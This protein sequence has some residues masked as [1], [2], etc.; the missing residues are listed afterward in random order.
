MRAALRQAFNTLNDAFTRALFCRK[1]KMQVAAAVASAAAGVESGFNSEA[2]PRPPAAMI[3]DLEVQTTPHSPPFPRHPGRKQGRRRQRRQVPAP[4][5]GAAADGGQLGDALASL[6]VARQPLPE[7]L[8][9]QVPLH[10]RG[11]PVPLRQLPLL[12][13]RPLLST[14]ALQHRRLGWQRGR[15]LRAGKQAKYEQHQERC[16]S[17]GAGGPAMCRRDGDVPAGLR[18]E[19]PLPQQAPQGKVQE[20]APIAAAAR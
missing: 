14:L 10:R 20:A 17:H 19:T 18:I 3:N 2:A 12:A 9:A 11:N 13:R 7:L 16:W 4:A 6:L 8:V 5:L 1:C 15:Q